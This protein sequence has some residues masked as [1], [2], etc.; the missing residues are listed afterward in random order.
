MAADAYFLNH[1]PHMRKVVF[2]VIFLLLV[3]VTFYMYW[4][5]Y[6]AAGAGTKEGMLQNF[7]RRGNVFK[8]YEGDMIQMGFGMRGSSISS[9]VFHFSVAD[10]RIADSLEHHCQGKL[11]LLHYTQYRRSLPWRGENYTSKNPDQKPGQYIVDRIEQVRD[12]NFTY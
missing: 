10:E 2:L 7:A 9:N 1:H 3:S 12:A 4:Y 6:N 5:Y 11:V 8:T